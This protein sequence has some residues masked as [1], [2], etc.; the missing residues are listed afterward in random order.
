MRPSSREGRKGLLGTAVVEAIV[1]E[2]HMR[3]AFLEK[4]E[5]AVSHDLPALTVAWSA[6]EDADNMMLAVDDRNREANYGYQ[7]LREGRLGHILPEPS[8]IG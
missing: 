3:D 7:R 4:G 1:G 8:A 2:A 6:T 5:C